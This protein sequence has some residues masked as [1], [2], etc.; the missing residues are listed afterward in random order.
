MAGSKE[1]SQLKFC[2]NRLRNP[3]PFKIPQKLK[4]KRISLLCCCITEV[5]PCNQ[6]PEA[7]KAFDHLWMQISGHFHAPTI[8]L[9][10]NT[11]VAILRR[12]GC[13]GTKTGIDMALRNRTLVIP[14]IRVS[15]HSG[16]VNFA[17]NYVIKHYATKAYG[18]MKVKLHHS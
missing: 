10:G 3:S 4:S 16:N 9:Q 8:L 17:L 12:G 7:M 13:V 14:F 2:V 5:L 18:E 15:T 1:T 11:A 6:R